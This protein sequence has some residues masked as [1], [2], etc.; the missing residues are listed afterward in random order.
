M[1]DWEGGSEEEE[2]GLKSQRPRRRKQ[3]V[4]VARPAMWP[5]SACQP[6]RERAR[7][8]GLL[9]LLLVV[10]VV[11]VAGGFGGVDGVGEEGSGDGGWRRGDSFCDVEERSKTSGVEGSGGSSEDMA[12]RDV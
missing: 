1:L 5:C 2:E 9:L 8:E 6:K 10:V 11:V 3:A 7:A 12:T 4:Q